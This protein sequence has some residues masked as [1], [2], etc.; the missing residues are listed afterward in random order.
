V[1]RRPSII[2]PPPTTRTGIFPVL[3]FIAVLAA[4]AVL[5]PRPVSAQFVTRSWVPWRTIETAH[6]EIHYPA[7]L[8]AWTRNTASTLDAIDS[9]VAAIVGYAPSVKTQIVVDNPY[10]IANGSAWPFLDRPVIN[11]WAAPP[12][13][14]EDIGEYRVWGQ[15]LTAHEF[16]H[17]AHLTRPSRN[18]FVRH[19]WQALPVNVGPITLNAPRWA[20]EGYATYAEGRVT[21]SG[22][23]HGAWRAAFLRQWALEGQLPRY[24]QLN[25]WGAY[26]GGEFA[27]LA[28]SAFLEWLTERPGAGDSS[29]VHVW[30]RLTA[31]QQR[32][33]D[34]AFTGVYGETPRALY[35]KFLAD[36]TGNALAVARATIAAGADT[37]VIQQRLSWGT[38]DPAVSPD[39]D[40]L[41]IVVR[42]ANAP[43]R[44]VVWRT[45]PEPDTARAR[46]DSIL[47]AR[48]PEDV[49]AR[50]ISPPPKHALATLRSQG[51]SYES[52]RFLRD[53]RIVLW[54]STPQGD[55]T[56]RPEIYL[57]NPRT[58]DV[59]R[60]THGA[61]VQDPDPAADGRSAVATRCLHGWCDLVT[62]SLVDG[63]VTR[64]AEGSATRSFYRPRLNPATGEALVSVHENGTWRLAVVTPRT[65]AIR[66]LPL[67][68]AD[69]ANWYDGAWV[70]ARSFV[71]V[72]DATGIPNLEYVSLD[73]IS[74]TSPLTRVTGAAVA[75]EPDARGRLWFLS[76]YS[77]GYDLRTVSQRESAVA[78]HD[79][80]AADSLR[81]IVLP[82]PPRAVAPFPL[83]AVSTARPF[84]VG[85]RLYRWI[86]APSADADGYGALL[87]L[88]SAD[89]IGRSEILL[90]LA[91]GDRATWRGG[92]LDVT[93]R[94]TRPSIRAE[95]F[96]AGQRPSATRSGVSL[97]S[98]LDVQ[99]RGALLGV[100]GS[101][102]VETWAAHYRA[103]ASRATIRGLSA[104]HL[105]GSRTLLTSD[106]SL[107]VSHR[108]PAITNS[109]IL[110]TSLATGRTDARDFSRVLVSGGFSTTGFGLLPISA[111]VAYGR[112][113]DNA[114]PFEQFT[115]GGEP[116]PL[117]DR[118]LLGQRLAMPALPLGIQRGTSALTYRLGYWTR[119]VEWY[120][121]G[122]STS[123][124][125]T[126]FDAWQ[127]VVGVE[128]SSSIDA[129]APAGTPAARARIGVGESLDAPFRK[130]V[131][132]YISL[133]LNP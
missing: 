87:G 113:S 22:R 97:G 80:A 126:R 120:Y 75:P 56:L 102:V 62:V 78:G 7:D 68:A 18:A 19:L 64:I 58:G 121:W 106:A 128:W 37:G 92:A 124:G 105:D 71:A 10:A 5:T 50:P 43:S 90:K 26:A 133:L 82:V 98:A 30:R 8:E 59:R 86:P 14:R 35:G 41:A 34:A 123:E 125:G 99:M 73:S 81:G 72:S 103:T 55:G 115:L 23:P 3:F 63:A 69:S 57:W 16:T 119:P 13:P 100:D 49:P 39:G 101:H 38:G 51:A 91:A 61:S 83:N 20:I 111:A 131:R 76:L 77:R 132:A 107:A 104:G 40:R 117:L 33:F 110:S 25:A 31:K 1:T 60:V 93:W 129:I 27:Y 48:D 46:R 52:P 85:A 108:T 2:L 109:G 28:G 88:T 94:G 74:L 112:T 42:S 116:S 36:V 118:S 70:S 44:V 29:L 12:D 15:M 24:E 122:G 114:P 6:F 17:I 21:G 89:V 130:Q 79:S 65:G 47:L 4:L 95:L 53:G 127:R 66:W 96:D 45:T 32:G 54:K 9:A 11:L 67:P 84:D